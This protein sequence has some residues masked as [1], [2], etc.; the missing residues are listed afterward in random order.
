MSR[1]C[2]NMKNDEA[3]WLFRWLTPV[4][5]TQDI[6]VRGYGTRLKIY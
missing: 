5:G 4:N 6:D 2:I 3:K 1:G